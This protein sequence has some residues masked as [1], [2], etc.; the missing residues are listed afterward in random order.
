LEGRV[1]L[2][3]GAGRGLGRAYAY[4]LADRGARVAVNNRSAEL[5]AE[6]VEEIAR[7]GGEAVAVPAD[8]EAAG[9]AQE[10]VDA[11]IEAF[12][13]LDILI[14]N[15]GGS[16]VPA[17]PFAEITPADRDASLRNNF[18]TAWDV[19]AAAWPKLLDQGYGR[20]ILTASPMSLYGLTGFA[21]YSAAKSALIGLCRVLAVE[22]AE[23]GV[24][25]NVLNPLANT[26][27]EPGEG[28]WAEWFESSFLPDH[29]AAGVAYLVDERNTATGEIFTIGGARIAR[30]SIIE[31]R[32]LVQE[33][34]TFAP[35]AVEDRFD[36]VL[37]GG[38]PVQFRT[39][40]EMLGYYG[41]LYGA[42][43]A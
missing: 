26:R 3:T 31:S 12:G 22:G 39:I 15:A 2:V 38:Q 37:D 25:V 6:V 9:A 32:G 1:V 10:I 24:T 11:T 42:P 33:V 43:G 29:V 17:A 21:P 8:L 5:G 14:N 28:A 19:T 23:R 16:E 35:E 30:V 36:T 41:Q 40:P 34:D 18:T 4:A 20:V 27:R 7:R 13:K